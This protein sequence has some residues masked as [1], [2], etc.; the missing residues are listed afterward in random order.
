MKR[1]TILSFAG[2][3][4]L[5]ST[6]TFA[7]AAEDNNNV[8]TDSNQ[9]TQNNLTPTPAAQN[10]Y[11]ALPAS[12]QKTQRQRSGT[13]IN[14]IDKQINSLSSQAQTLE[15]KVK[16]LNADVATLKK[17]RVA[18]EATHTK[19]QAEIERN[20]RSV[21]TNKEGIETNRE[22]ILQTQITQARLHGLP[23]PKQTG[24]PVSL[25]KLQSSTFTLGSTV[26]TSPYL[27]LRSAFDASD[28]LTSLPSMNE[29]LRLL[30]QRRELEQRL[31]Q[32]GEVPI[33]ANRP[34]IELSGQVTAQGT[35]VRP[36]QGATTSN[37]DLTTAEIDALILASTWA[38]A[39]ISLQYD[40]SLLP[41][42]AAPGNRISNSRFYL[43]RGFLTIGDLTEFPLYITA[44]QMY[45][46]FGNYASFAVTDPLTK[47]M[48]RT[49]QRAVLLGLE[50][51]GFYAQAYT[52]KGP[53]NVS[54]PGINQGGLNGGFKYAGP[55][56]TADV[57]AGYILNMADSGGMQNTGVGPS[58]TIP[59]M[60]F[61]GFGVPPN[62]NPDIIP[63]TS[64]EFLYNRVPGVDLHGTL[65]YG[66][67]TLIGEY[68]GATKSFNSINLSFN[69]GGAQPKAMQLEGVYAFNFVQRPT[70]I[71]LSYDQSWQALGLNLPQN[72]IIGA[73]NIS[74]WK[75]TVESIE[76]RHDIN[77]SSN[78]T[79]SGNGAPLPLNSLGS[80]QNTVTAQLA[81]YF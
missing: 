45:V 50:K 15:T 62:L 77:Y 80:Y 7:V 16:A 31:T 53:S 64:N 46:P 43:T 68:V 73:L 39:F 3:F 59:Q 22:R 51:S 32:L 37:I 65:M 72:S 9:Q 52:F 26:T 81:V 29:D 34:L 28:L 41:F 24:G 75:D 6:S 49:N 78:D 40:N 58:Y 21:E 60:G 4:I 61:Q 18:G 13:S 1:R 8:V 5:A 69:G 55:K 12:N 2:L 54:A 19:L 17:Q 14:D 67:I 10:N 71:S 66:P 42:T 20:Q 44:G 63:S 57:G 76:F 47:T 70:N 48:A 33:Y 56:L 38:Q 36:F 35:Y 74:I 79:S 11:V 23:M 25:A 30:Q 27:G